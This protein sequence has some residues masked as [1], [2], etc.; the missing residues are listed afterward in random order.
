M[1]K[2]YGQLPSQVR[3][4]AT[5]YDIRVTEAMLSW[6]IK[7]QEAAATGRP[8]LPKLTQEQMKGMLAKVKG[9]SHV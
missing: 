2:L 8:A 4:T 9:E 6:E 1:A 5:L 7:I 3:D